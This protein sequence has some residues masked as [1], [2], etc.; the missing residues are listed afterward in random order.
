M[1]SM[2][3]NSH[4]YS[5]RGCKRSFLFFLLPERSRRG[6]FANK[7]MQQSGVWFGIAV[8]PFASSQGYPMD[9]FLQVSVLQANFCWL[10]DLE[11]VI[12]LLMEVDSVEKNLIHG[13]WGDVICRLF[14]MG[15][16]C[17]TSPPPPSSP[18]NPPPLKVG[19]LPNG[20]TQ[21]SQ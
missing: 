5:D 12:C 1:M 15:Y 4:T 7:K 20:H 11:E 2:T 10:G 19:I 18:S 8:L 21:T 3:L 14:G 17:E 6:L 13:F 16:F 9:L